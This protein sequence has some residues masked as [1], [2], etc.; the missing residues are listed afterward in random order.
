MHCCTHCDLLAEYTSVNNFTYLFF[1]CV[2]NYVRKVRDL[3]GV[4][5]QLI[6]IWYNLKQSIIDSTIIYQWRKRLTG[7]VKAKGG[8]YEYQL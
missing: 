5:E 4:R 8:H 7:C 1:A 3:D 2:I 6:V